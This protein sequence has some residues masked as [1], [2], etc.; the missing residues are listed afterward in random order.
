[1]NEHA[2][3]TE[4]ITITKGSAELLHIYIPYNL[5]YIERIR[6]IKGRTWESKQKVWII[7]YT[8]SAIQEFMNQFDSED[9]QIAP[10]LWVESEDLQQWKTSSKGSNAWSKE[11]LQKALTLRG[12][13]RKTIKAYCNQVERFLSS[14]ALKDTDVTSSKVQTYC[15]GLLEQGISHSSVNQTISA[16]RFYCKHV[17]HHPTEIQYIRPKKQIKL[18]KVMSEKEV[19]QLLKSVTNLKHKTILFLTYSSGLRVGEVVR[20]QCSDLDI[21]RQT[22]IVRHGKGQK[23][24]RTLLSN[25]A[26]E[27]VQEYITEYR[28]NRWLFPG[29]ASDRHLTERSV[30]KV[31]EEARQRAGIVK[32]VSIHALRHSFATHLL[33]NGTDLRYIQELLGHTSARTT[34]RYTHVSMKNIQR[35]QSPLDRL[36]LGE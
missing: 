16:I 6:R 18:P 13:S 21:E 23:D 5:V 33:E 12:Y 11:P 17:L 28:P 22:L 26:W 7:P 2:T 32:K 19:A 15:L 27:I 24:R 35:I 34:Q 14:L 29:Q 36:D 9:V 31:F 30:Q 10:E 8:T 4:T 1:M 3:T 20:L 25:L